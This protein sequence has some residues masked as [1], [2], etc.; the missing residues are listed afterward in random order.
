MIKAV[1]FDFDGLILD[2][3][4]AWYKAYK[5]VFGRYGVDL[6]LDFWGKTIGTVFNIDEVIRYLQDRSGR[7]VDKDQIN[8]ETKNIS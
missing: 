5:E 1:I 2:T 4:T 7:T 6:T 8:A 3:E